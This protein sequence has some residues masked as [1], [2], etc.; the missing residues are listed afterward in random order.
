[1]ESQGVR[2]E[3]LEQCF[4][5]FFESQTVNDGNFF[6]QIINL[7]GGPFFVSFVQQIAI[8]RQILHVLSHQ[9]NS[10]DHFKNFGGP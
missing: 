9:K 8:F 5:N 7:L 2:G 10:M 1:M 6:L 3:G 4:P